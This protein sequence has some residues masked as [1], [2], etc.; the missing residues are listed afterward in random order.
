MLSYCRTRVLSYGGWLHTLYHVLPTDH[1]TDESLFNVVKFQPGM[2]RNASTNDGSKLF[3]DVHWEQCFRICLSIDG[4]ESFGF[5]RLTSFMPRGHLNHVLIHRFWTQQRLKWTSTLWRNNSS[6]NETLYNSTNDVKTWGRGKNCEGQWPD[7]TSMYTE[8]SKSKSGW[9]WS[10]SV[11]I[12]RDNQVRFET[13]V[14]IR[15]TIFV[16]VLICGFN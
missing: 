1:T 7:G 5:C 11:S 3:P 12:C 13:L 6:L 10:K 14:T 4:N 2:S 8:D 16:L 15:L 9:R